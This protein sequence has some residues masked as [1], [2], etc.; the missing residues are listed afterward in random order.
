MSLLRADAGG[1]DTAASMEMSPL[2]SRVPPA[3]G[4]DKRSSMEMRAATDLR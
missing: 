1:S 2:A 4:T 3:Q